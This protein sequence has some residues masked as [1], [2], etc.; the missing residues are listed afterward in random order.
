MWGQLDKAISYYRLL[1]D[2]I[3]KSRVFI[4]LMF[5]HLRFPTGIRSYQ[6]RKWRTVQSFGALIVQYNIVYVKF[7]TG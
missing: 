7:K 6:R 2:Q 5:R 4:N 1:I 3:K